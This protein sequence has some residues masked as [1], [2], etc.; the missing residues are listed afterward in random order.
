MRGRDIRTGQDAGRARASLLRCVGDH[1]LAAEAGGTLPASLWTLA[2]GAL[3]MAPF[4]SYLS[5]SLLAGTDAG[6]TTLERYAAEAGVEYGI[7]N[8]LNDSAFRLQVDLAP[9]TPYT[10]G[11]AITVN[12]LSPTMSAEA[13]PVGI[14]TAMANHPTNIGSGAA[15][16]HDYG[17]YIYALRG[18]SSEFRRY[19]I[20]GNSWTSLASTPASIGAGGALAYAGGDYVYALR[21]GTAR[22]FYRYSISGN[23]WSALAQTPANIGAGGSLVFVGGDYLFA[24]RGANQRTFYR[25]SISG[26]S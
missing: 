2:V 25:Y 24:L 6:E 19:S 18:G 26:N 14:W 8:L 10:P 16:A 13:I 3:V 9:G 21:G 15:L 12:G 22:Q 1:A 4:L 17:D 20:S 11:P 5:T 7:W 23:S